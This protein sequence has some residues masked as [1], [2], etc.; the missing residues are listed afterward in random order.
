MNTLS[1]VYQPAPGE[2][3]TISITLFVEGKGNCADISDAMLLTILP[4]AAVNA[5]SDLAT[6]E[7]AP[8]VISGANASN[9]T[10]I[11][12]TTNGNGTFNNSSIINPVYTPGSFDAAVGEVILTLTAGG[13]SPC[14]SVSDNLVVTISKAPL[15]DAG[16][17]AVTCNGASYT[18]TQAS[19]ENYNT[20]LWSLSPSSAGTLTNTSSLSPTYTPAAGFTGM[21]TLTFRVQGAGSCGDIVVSDVMFVF[22]NTELSADAGP[23]QTIYPGT[24]T[25]LSGSVA[26]GSGFYAWNWQPEDYL[27]NP[28]IQNPATTILNQETTFTLTVMDLST[29]CTADDEVVISIGSGNNSIVAVPD[30]D[31]TLVNVPVTVNVLANDINPDADPLIV[32]LCGFPVHGIVVLNSDKTITY[33]PYPEF[34]GDDMFCYRIC[35]ALQPALCSDTMVYI[36]VKKPDLNDIFVFNGVSPNG[37]GNNDTWKIRGIE[38]YPDN[39]ILIFNRWGDKVREFAGYNNSSRSWDGTNEKGD[40]LPNGTYFYIL[41][42]KNVGV[43]KG[44]IYV[45][46]ED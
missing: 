7:L 18:V 27:L 25:V 12:W 4:V 6:C 39:T 9:S 10:S 33:T 13:N 22:I 19:A 40:P 16:P 37:D 8:V 29:G 3:G 41:D 46:G 20:L 14:P 5:G 42:V 15:A 28:S 21:A 36:H 2:S 45:R 32:S 31:T 30:H 1:P 38:R 23:D 43:L 11:L 24:G 34:E 26:G 17:D 44:W 35:N